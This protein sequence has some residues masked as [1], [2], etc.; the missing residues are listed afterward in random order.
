MRLEGKR[1]LIT[2][3]GSGIGRALAIRAASKGMI[4]A[5]CGRRPDALAETAAMLDRPAAHIVIS[6]D[7]TLPVDRERLRACVAKNW[8]GLDILVNNAGI[9]ESGSVAS[10]VDSALER[11]FAI[12]VI[13]PIALV[14]DML[15]LL[16]IGR[17]SRVI[18]IGSVFGDIPYPF[19][20]AYSASKFALRGF[21]IA[22]RREMDGRGVGVTYA[23]PRAT[24][25]EALGASRPLIQKMQMALDNPKSVAEQIWRAVERDADSVYPRGPERLY[26]FL[27]RVLPRVIDSALSKQMAKLVAS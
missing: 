5:L 16:E 15:P 23:A 3:A 7:I 13:A 19:F 20:A 18:N 1:A 26:V 17:P 24:Q 8:S 4:L 12:N 9:I 25:T 11:L 6:A 14:R 22:L 2:G 21:S 27:Q 10:V